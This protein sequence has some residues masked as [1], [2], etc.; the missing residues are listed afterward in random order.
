M[1]TRHT[2]GSI[3]NIMSTFRIG[4]VERIDFTPI[5]KKPGFGENVDDVVMSAFVHFSDPIL[6]DDNCYNYTSDSY[7]RDNNF[8]D[9]ISYDQPYRLQVS[10]NEYWIC[11]KNKKPV[12]YT[13]MNIHQVV[14][15][16]RYLENLIEEQNNK[17]KELEKKIDNMN[18][19]IRQLIGGLYCQNTQECV[20]ETHLRVLDGET[21]SSKPT[22]QDT[23]KWDH[24]PTTRQ[25]DDCER[26]IE[27]LEN[28][29]RFMLPFE[30]PRHAH[31]SP[32]FNCEEQDSYLLMRKY[33]NNN[34]DCYN[35]STSSHSSM[36]DLVND[37]SSVSTHSSMPDLLDMDSDDSNNR[38]K[39]SWELCG[40]E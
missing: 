20:L 24:W 22:E 16:G 21:S 7:L 3:K 33:E 10:Y 2:L 25:G 23:H 28:S 32:F 18:Q 13:M 17:I 8:W 38:I 30:N 9:T 11:L 34:M 37:Y 6:G 1:S 31:I 19:V 36:P 27:Q 29:M 4:T 12:R 14:E 26:R 40:N 5:N 15:N 35:D 39:N